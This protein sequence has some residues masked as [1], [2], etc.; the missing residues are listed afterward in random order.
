MTEHE[1]VSVTGRK[2]DARLW[3]PDGEIRGLVQLIHGMAE[4]IERYD[5]IARALNAA[6]YVVMGHNQLGHGAKAGTLGWFA[7]KDGWQCLID[8]VHKLRL[9]AE[10]RFP[11]VP[12]FLLGHSMGSFIARCYITEHG[13]GMSGAVI[14]GTGWYSRSTVR[15]GLMAAKAVCRAG[16]AAKPSKLLDGLAFSANNKPFEPSRTPNDW[17][18]RDTAQ[19][20]RYAA[21][22]LC[23]FVF[24]G[25]GFR[26]LFTGL[27]RLTRETELLRILKELPILFI[28]GGNDPVGGM[29]KGVRKV[30]EQYRRA[31]L[32]DVELKIY[33]DARH[34][35]FNEIGHEQTEQDLTRWLE[36]HI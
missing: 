11:G 24:T 26:D 21:D 9:L 2:L 25:G 14:S 8:D 4:H 27:K 13:E 31:G 5:R 18:S 22:P 28:S 6:G 3:L 33:P 35:L 23:G 15:A 34:E 17:L 12:Y 30:E 19:V 16:G 29:G 20:D 32:K 7:E 10:K 1:F 36:K